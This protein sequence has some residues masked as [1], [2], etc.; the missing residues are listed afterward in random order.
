MT[1]HFKRHI[2]TDQTQK[3]DVD[4]GNGM[5][6]DV[7]ILCGMHTQQRL[8][9]TKQLMLIEFEVGYT[10]LHVPAK[11]GNGYSHN[12]KKHIKSMLLL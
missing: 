3:V 4:I 7:G 2:Q 12:L 11:G 10:N 5:I 6:S 1:V 8:Q 9:Q